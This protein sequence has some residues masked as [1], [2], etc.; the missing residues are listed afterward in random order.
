MSKSKKTYTDLQRDIA[1][2][3]EQAEGL[4]GQK[5]D[6]ITSAFEKEFKKKAF[7]EK[8]IFA[9]DAVLKKAVKDIVSNFDSILSKAKT[10]LDAE[11]QKSQNATTPVVPTSA[12]Q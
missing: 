1:K 5:L 12:L 11:T 4:K 9:D 10:E 2:L 6:V 7:Q 8:V 3:I